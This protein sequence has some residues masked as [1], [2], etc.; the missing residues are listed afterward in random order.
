MKSPFLFLA[1]SA[2][3]IAVCPAQN[4]PSATVVLQSISSTAEATTLPSSVQEALDFERSRWAHGSVKTDSFYDVPSNASKLPAGSLI[5]VQEDANSSVYTIPPSTAISRFIYQSKTLNGSLVPVSAYILWPLSPRKHNDGYH[6]VAW[7]HGSSGISPECAPSHVRNLWQHFLAPYQLA[8]QGYVVVAT[9]YA[10]LGVGADGNGKAITHEYL[11]SPAAANDVIYSVQAARQAFPELSRSFV[12]AGHS[13]GG[14]AVWAIAHKQAVSPIPGYLGAVAVSPLTDNLG[15]AD[16]VGTILGAI[17]APAIA[18]V[19]S[20]F[21]LQDIVT[22]EGLQLMNQFLAVGGC[23]IIKDLLFG[24]AAAGT[25]L[26]SNWRTNTWVRKYN[27]LTANYDQKIGGPLLI[28][29]GEADSLLSIN[30]TVAAVSATI[31]RYPTS[32]LEFLR[33]P[34]T[35]HNAALT[36][37]QSVWMDW[38]ADRFKG[39]PVLPFN[40]NKRAITEAVVARPASAYVPELNWYIELATESYETP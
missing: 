23:T 38:I 35:S 14:G 24:P 9:D 8:L 22:P 20:D 1:C 25:L 26:T 15:I 36:G 12:A 2:I 19:F 11:A 33:L 16:P 28:V 37:G 27:N 18:S 6:V 13:Q 31:S 3:L 5:K 32:Q 34:S 10:G 4:A 40:K 39:V 17:T 21:K 29:H 30:L 7:A